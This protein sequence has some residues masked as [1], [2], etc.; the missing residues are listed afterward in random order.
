MRQ[1][2]LPGV[3]AQPREERLLGSRAIQWITGDG[4]A[5]T[6]KVDANLVAAPG[7]GDDFEQ[8]ERIPR[9]SCE[10]PIPR[11]GGLAARISCGCHAIAA[12]AVARDRRVDD[13]LRLAG[14]AHHQG[15][16]D[17]AH[18]TAL[19][20]GC[21]VAVGLRPRT[22]QQHARRIRIEPLVHAEVA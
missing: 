11:P 6:R 14:P 19:E 2:E 22:E 9:R 10:D 3:Q 12:V 21:E 16:V 18:R 15:E 7:L 1:G 13:A 17:L 8:G 4:A 20:R 5:D